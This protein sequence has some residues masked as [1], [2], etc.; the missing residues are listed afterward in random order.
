MNTQV[1]ATEATVNVAALF[2]QASKKKLRFDNPNG[3]QL[4]TEDLWDLPL[5]SANKASLDRLAID[6]FKKLRDSEALSFVVDTTASADNVTQLKFDIVRHVI[7]TRKAE[8]AAKLD[9][10]AKADRKRE[11]QQALAAARAGDLA[12]KTPEEIEAMIAAL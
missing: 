11:L 8:N 9:A 10:Q 7:E 2:E 1:T 3:G 6:L 12:K 4:S 5:T